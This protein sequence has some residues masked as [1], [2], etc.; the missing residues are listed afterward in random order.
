[1][2][3][4][5][6]SGGRSSAHARKVFSMTGSEVNSAPE[7]VDLSPIE[8][9]PQ[10]AW[11]ALAEKRVYFGHQS[12]GY[13][14]LAGVETILRAKPSLRLRL[15]ESADPA[16]LREPALVHSKIGSNTDPR[17]KLQAFA[18]FLDA[19]AGK[20]ADAAFF[21]LCYVDIGPKADP[22]SLFEE[23]SRVMNEL[24]R[25]HSRVRLL[26]VTVPLTTVP[27]GPKQALKILLGRTPWGYE[28]NRIRGE[29]NRMIRNAYAE[30]G[31]LFD[32]A[33]VEATRPGGGAE[34]YSWKGASHDAM[35]PGYTSDDGH[36][37][38]VGRLIAAREF[39]V[40][41]VGAAT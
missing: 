26:H 24:G 36:L 41:L 25:R 7:S 35:F 21:K 17:S 1:M 34:T 5:P 28:H 19:G 2:I 29:Y 38:A 13:N 11:D 31:P 33:R 3:R 14:I 6:S 37:S 8:R 27:R 18:N 32:L 15:V 23:Y 4:R 40:W 39:L 10:D 30:R 12:V 22:A 20:F 16:A 9:V